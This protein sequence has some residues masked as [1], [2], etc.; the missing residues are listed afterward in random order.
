VPDMQHMRIATILPT[1]CLGLDESD[2]HMC[3]AHLMGPGPYRDWFAQK[4]SAGEHV[5][6]AT[7]PPSAGCRCRPRPCS[8]WRPAWGPP[9]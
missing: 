3:L 1:S 7:D 5:L 8:T 6:M 4:A 9:R 2:Y